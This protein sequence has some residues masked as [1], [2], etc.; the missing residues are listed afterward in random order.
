MSAALKKTK[1]VMVICESL[2][3]TGHKVNRIKPKGTDKLEF[4]YKDP[5]IEQ[6]VLYRELKKLRSI[7]TK[8]IKKLGFKN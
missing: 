2:A 6:V 7:T 8:E 4:L 1:L 5:L 3:G